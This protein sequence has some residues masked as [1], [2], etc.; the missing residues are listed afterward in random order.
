MLAR[1]A[2]EAA[3]TQEGDWAAAELSFVK[4]QMRGREGSLSTFETKDPLSAGFFARFY[5]PLIAT[6]FL[7]TA[8]NPTGRGP[9]WLVRRTLR[10]RLPDMAWR[11]R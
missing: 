4:E 1:I 10:L 3:G 8:T 9:R 6:S 2:E 11:L 7:L 5:A